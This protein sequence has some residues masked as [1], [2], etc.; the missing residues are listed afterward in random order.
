M[1]QANLVRR[2]SSRDRGKQVNTPGRVAHMTVSNPLTTDMTASTISV[3]P[4]FL[5]EPLTLL[6][7]SINQAFA[8]L[9]AR[10]SRDIAK[11][12]ADVSEHQKRFDTVLNEVKILRKE[13]DAAIKKADNAE[14]EIEQSNM[15]LQ[16][17]ES[18]ILVQ[19]EAIQQLK[20]EAAHWKDHARNW[21]EHFLKVEQDR[22]AMSTRIDE[23]VTETRQVN[24]KVAG[25]QPE[26]ALSTTPAPNQ[27]SSA[28]SS[29]TTKRASLSNKPR[30][31]NRCESPIEAT[32]NTRKSQSKV[33]TRHDADDREAGPSSTKIIK[34]SDSSSIEV[35]ELTE[36]SAS[37][38][39]TSSSATEGPRQSILLRRVH[40]TIETKIKDEGDSD[41]EES[42]LR[43]E[44]EAGMAQKRA[45]RITQPHSPTKRKSSRKS[46][47]EEREDDEESSDSPSPLQRR[48]PSKRPRLALSDD[49][50]N[51]D[52]SDDDLLLHSQHDDSDIFDCAPIPTTYKKPAALPRRSRPQ[53]GTNTTTQRRKSIADPQSRKPAVRSR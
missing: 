37:S 18:T 50:Y 36:S 52:E 39:S 53:T 51:E 4:A 25:K 46:I 47:Q 8:D 21:Q 43:A 16:K 24:S 45:S 31:A 29:A 14:E 35:P 44:R 12:N 49:D 33:R 7:N 22:C 48:Q 40:A 19:A 30:S 6:A 9:E 42:I 27:P 1:A 28:L 10:C 15:N 20:R 5:A 11:A 38:S 23:L 34:T 26:R 17:A 41:N 3:H 32:G 13:R 2:F